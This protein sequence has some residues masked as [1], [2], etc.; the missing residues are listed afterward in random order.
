MP[1]KTI[2]FDSFKLPFMKDPYEEFDEEVDE[3]VEGPDHDGIFDSM[4]AALPPGAHCLGNVEDE[5]RNWTS[6]EIKFHLF[7]VPLDTTTAR[8]ALVRINWDD[9]WGRWGWE[10]CA[11]AT[12][13]ATVNEA[14]VAMVEGVFIKWGIDLN[15]KS[16]AGYRKFLDRL[17]R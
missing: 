1:E 9:N 16:G 15:A 4:E 11:Q 5:V 13:F 6:W 14:A 12:G 8:Y 10:G 3:E 17:R 2:S 7:V